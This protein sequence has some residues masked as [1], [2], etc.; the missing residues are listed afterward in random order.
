MR[1]GGRLAPGDLYYVIRSSSRPF[2]LYDRSGGWTVKREDARRFTN[3]EHNRFALPPDGA[4]S[5]RRDEQALLD[6]GFVKKVN[7]PRAQR[8]VAA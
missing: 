7:K 8:R 5:F 6:R 1:R 2:F 4:W 3:T